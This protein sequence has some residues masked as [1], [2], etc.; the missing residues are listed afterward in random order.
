MGRPEVNAIVGMKISEAIKHLRENDLE[1]RITIQDG[2]SLMVD[3]GI[4]MKRVN[5]MVEGDTVVE[6]DKIG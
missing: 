5:V 1:F 4:E 3:G 6:I 2:R